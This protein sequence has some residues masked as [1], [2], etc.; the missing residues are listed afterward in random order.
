MKLS[1]RKLKQIIKEELQEVLK[2]QAPKPAGGKCLLPN[3]KEVP[4]REPFKWEDGKWYIA[5][6]RCSERKAYGA[7]GQKCDTGIPGAWLTHIE[8]WATSPEVGKYKDTYL[9]YFTQEQADQGSHVGGTW[10]DKGPAGT[11]D[12]PSHKV[13]KHGRVPYCIAKPT[14]APKA[15]ATQGLEA[16]PKE[17]AE[18]ATF[19]SQ[20]AK[21][22]SA[23]NTA[24]LTGILKGHFGDAGV[25]AIMGYGGE[26]AVDRAF[27]RA[28]GAVIAAVE[29][30]AGTRGKRGK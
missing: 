8:S 21:A 15:K 26:K 23:G 1:Q 9:R 6:Q 18:A 19:M 7:G 12:R 16:T 10:P 4:M 17:A 22:L 13:K 25:R 30:A 5:T 11:Y 2:E 24:A 27:R 20:A 29:Y 3:L 14:E 28:V